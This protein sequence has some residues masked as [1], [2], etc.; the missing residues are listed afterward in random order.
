[1]ARAAMMLSCT[2][3]ASIV[4][5]SH[6]LHSIHSHTVP[7]N[8]KQP[9]A[10]QNMAKWRPILEQSPTFNVTQAGGWNT[11]E[12]LA[13]NPKDELVE[14]IMAYNNGGTVNPTKVI[15]LVG[16]LQAQGKGYAANLVNGEWISVLSQEGTKSP[17]IQKLVSSKE[18]TRTK[19]SYANFDV[20]HQKFYGEVSI[21]KYGSLQSTVAVSN[22]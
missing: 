1:M 17:K 13:A 4:S 22:L 9:S 14:Y 3:F 7:S 6:N 16:L 10:A 15:A 19:P 2:L 5:F 11:V 8:S 20:D 21:L 12:S 18:Q